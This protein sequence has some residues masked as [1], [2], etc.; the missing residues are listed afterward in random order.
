MKARILSYQ[1][2]EEQFQKVLI[3][4]NLLPLDEESLKNNASC[5]IFI[6]TLCISQ[7]KAPSDNS[8]PEK[9]KHLATLE[10]ASSAIT[11]KMYTCSVEEIKMQVSEAYKAFHVH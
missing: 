5:L 3:E 2:V 11:Y 8:Y 7:M 10:K 6:L 9:S 1:E 4:L